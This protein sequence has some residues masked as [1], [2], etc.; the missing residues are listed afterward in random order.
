MGSSGQS[1]SS[2][3][4]RADAALGGEGGSRGRSPGTGA[5]MALNSAT[6]SES[7][8][9]IAGARESVFS[10]STRAAALVPDALFQVASVRASSRPIVRH[11]RRIS[12]SRV[13][14]EVALVPGAYFR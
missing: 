7:V 6:S 2:A 13:W 5:A 11:A 3:P 12:C 9:S 10:L 8:A 14:T 4:P 1:I